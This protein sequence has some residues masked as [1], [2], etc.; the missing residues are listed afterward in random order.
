MKNRPLV[1]RALLPAV[2]VALL[3][4]VPLGAVADDSVAAMKLGKTRVKWEPKVDYASILLTVS[5]PDGEVTREEF[6]YPRK[7]SFRLPNADGGYVFELTVT[8]RV[9]EGLH[10]AMAVARESGDDSFGRDLSRAGVLPQGAKQSGHFRVAG[11]QIVSDDE[12]EDTGDA[13]ELELGNE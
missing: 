7:P 5:G 1:A 11:G 12:V 10:A 9:E 8:P 3:C 2:V 13:E 4:G 6:P